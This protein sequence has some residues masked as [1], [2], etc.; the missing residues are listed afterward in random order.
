MNDIN[1]CPEED[2]M[3]FIRRVLDYIETLPPGLAPMSSPASESLLLDHAP[4][5]DL[6]SARSERMRDTTLELEGLVSV[7]D[8]R[9]LSTTIR[10]SIESLSNIEG[11]RDIRSSQS[12]P[13]VEL[14]RRT[15]QIYTI[16]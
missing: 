7:E 15:K 14:Y 12:E 5:N 2:Q 3:K 8:Q 4:S 11:I 16:Q 9:C 10:Q 1:P 6:S 13:R